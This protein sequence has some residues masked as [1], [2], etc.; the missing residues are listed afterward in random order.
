MFL[1]W[2]VG[3]LALLGRGTVMAASKP[4]IIYILVDDLGY[5]DVNLNHPDLPDRFRHPEIRTPNLARLASEGVVFT[6]HYAAAPT[7]SPSRAGLLTGRTPM[8]SNIHLWIN[9]RADNDK[10]FLRGWEVTIPELLKKAGYTAA[11]F[12]KW[13]LNGADWEKPES[14]TGWTGSFPLQQGFDRAIVSKEDPHLTRS[15]DQ[16]TQHR[17]GDFFDGN[18]RPMGVIPGWTSQIITDY[19]IEWVREKVDQQRPFFLYL[20]YDAVHE[21]VD[22]PE[23]WNAQYNTGVKNKD[24]YYANVSFLDHQIGRLLD[25]LDALGIGQ[26]TIVFFSSDNG[27]EVLRE[28]WGT[29]RSYGISYPLR[30]HKRQLYEGGI[31]VPGMVRWRGRIGPRVSRAPNSTLDV[32]PTLCEIAGVPLPDDRQYDGVSLVGHLLRNEPIERRCPLYWQLEWM[33]HWETDGQGYQRRYDG[34]RPIKD[35]PIP[36]VVIR[37]GDHVLRGLHAGWREGRDMFAFPRQFELF[38]VVNDPDEKVNLVETRP[39]VFQK[40]LGQMKAMHESVGKDRRE[41]EAWIRNNRPRSRG[42]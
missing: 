1:W 27:P 20:P 10:M 17:P 35:R 38:E 33:Q 24:R 11:V 30:G 18:G 23:Q 34:T 13:H 16:N 42:E 5:G 14:W 15:L 3:L 19:A 31:R 26:D 41:S 12:G 25:E 2:I 4:N 32:L 8:R 29:Y 21:K 36:Q 28:Y 6:D 40:L 39:A 7:C 9:D 37:D 22:N